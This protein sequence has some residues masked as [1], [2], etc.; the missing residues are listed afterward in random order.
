MKSNQINHVVGGEWKS[1]TLINIPL[2]PEK[3]LVSFVVRHGPG[4]DSTHV[5]VIEETDAVWIQTSKGVIEFND[6]YLKARGMSS[7]SAEELFNIFAD[8]IENAQA[9]KGLL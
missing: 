6:V 5:L 7:A 1:S 3:S 9:V 2:N 8:A 4:L